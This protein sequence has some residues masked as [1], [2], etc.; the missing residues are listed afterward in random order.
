MLTVDCYSDGFLMLKGPKTTEV[1][2]TV[3]TEDIEM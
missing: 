2:L 3:G 1:E